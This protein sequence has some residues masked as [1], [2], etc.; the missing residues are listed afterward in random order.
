[1]L[2]HYGH[3]EAIPLR[4]L[5]WGVAV[6]GAARLQGTLRAGWKDALLF[7]DLATLRD[8]AQLF[9]EVDE[10]RWTGPAAGFDRVAEALGEPGLARR[11]ERLAAGRDHGNG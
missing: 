8:H 11:V 2:A 6:R 5:P 7:R 10:L 1:M 4:S 9:R 3:L